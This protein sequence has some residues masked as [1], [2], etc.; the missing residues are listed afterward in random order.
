M[1]FFLTLCSIKFADVVEP[2][3]WFFYGACHST[4]NLSS[5]AWELF[6]P[7]G[8]LV[9]LQG[10]YLGRTSNNIV[11]YNVVIELLS[12]AVSLGIINLVVKLGSQLVVLQLNNHYSVRNQ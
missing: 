5:V 11:E 1:L 7:D 3:C 4:R 12:E 8:A 2:L 10:I 6:T 9:D